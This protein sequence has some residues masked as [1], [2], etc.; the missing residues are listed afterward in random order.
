MS[1]KDF[2]EE[3]RYLFYIMHSIYALLSIIILLQCLYVS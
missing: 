2:I 1:R 3:F